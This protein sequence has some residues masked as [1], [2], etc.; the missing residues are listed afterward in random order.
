MLFGDEQNKD[1]LTPFL[2]AALPQDGYEEIGL[3]NPFFPGEALDD[4]YG[5]VRLNA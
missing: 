2:K 1:I 5:R 4:K 3:L